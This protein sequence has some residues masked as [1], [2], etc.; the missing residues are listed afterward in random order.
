MWLAIGIRFDGF[1][2]WLVWLVAHIFCLSGFR[3]RLFVMAQLAWY[4]LTREHGARVIVLEDESA[5]VKSTIRERL[6]GS[7]YHVDGQ[8]VEVG[9]PQTDAPR[10]QR[11]AGGASV[12]G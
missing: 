9:P 11:D 12:M 4:Y 8:R 5:T 7:H 2:A 3:D 6:T 1:L 10:E